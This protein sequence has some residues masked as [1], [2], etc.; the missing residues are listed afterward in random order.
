MFSFSVSKLQNELEKLEARIIDYSNK[1]ALESKPPNEYVSNS[2]LNRG[3]SKVGNIGRTISD[4]AVS[5]KHNKIKLEVYLNMKRDLKSSNRMEYDQS[6]ISKDHFS[7]TS[8]DE[9]D[10]FEFEASLFEIRN[11]DSERNLTKYLNAIFL[12]DK[13]TPV[14]MGLKSS[15]LNESLR[16][17]ELID[18]TG[19]HVFLLKIPETIF[20]I[21]NNKAMDNS[22]RSDNAFPFGLSKLYQSFYGLKN[23]S[24]MHYLKVLYSKLK[25]VSTMAY[26]EFLFDNKNEQDI[27]VSCIDWNVYK[28]YISTMTTS[29]VHCIGD[30]SMLVGF[31]SSY[32]I[33]DV[34]SSNESSNKS[35]LNILSS[36]MDIIVSTLIISLATLVFYLLLKKKV[37]NIQQENINILREFS[38]FKSQTSFEIMKINRILFTIRSDLNKMQE[39][40]KMALSLCK[41]G[42]D[43]HL[44]M[45]TVNLNNLRTGF[46]TMES[47][48]KRNIL[49]DKIL[50]KQKF[51]S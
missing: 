22:K 9:Y 5:N 7:H 8:A 1:T 25:F 29:F 3:E 30:L 36:H 17:I 50:G 16:D 27:C 39:M 12:I 40:N 34:E 23:L 15:I 32:L 35:V 10:G 44:K 24:I 43:L 47:K 2:I 20:K 37:N 48:L 28:S 4:K 18:A 31:Y 33:G 41:Q 19:T 51:Y 42:V 6:D 21:L 49:D 45:S 38:S 46:E 13:S 26:S 14:R 11:N